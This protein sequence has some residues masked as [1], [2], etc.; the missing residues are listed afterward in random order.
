VIDAVIII[1]MVLV[2]IITGIV[3]VICIDRDGRIFCPP[4]HRRK[5]T[6][7]VRH[8]E[9]EAPLAARGEGVQGRSPRVPEGQPDVPVGDGAVRDR[10]R[11]DQGP[12]DAERLHLERHSRAPSPARRLAS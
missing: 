10:A 6:R 11:D 4:H 5:G 2:L 1:A 12:V 7:R 3:L 9:D 8:L